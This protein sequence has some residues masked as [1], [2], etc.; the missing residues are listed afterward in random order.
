MKSYQLTLPMVLTLFACF[1]AE[2]D[3]PAEGEDVSAIKPLVIPSNT[4]RAREKSAPRQARK[5]QKKI[6]KNQFGFGL[7]VLTLSSILI[8]LS[9]F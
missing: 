6:A 5:I 2:R 8:I 7:P 3:E 9:L 1:G 4:E